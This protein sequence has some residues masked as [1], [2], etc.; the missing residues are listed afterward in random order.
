MKVQKL[1]MKLKQKLSKDFNLQRISRL[2]ITYFCS[3]HIH[4]NYA[5]FSYQELI[6]R[7]S[8]PDLKP[9]QIYPSLLVTDK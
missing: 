3:K 5:N 9:P 6:Q 7:H 1:L 8:N 4:Q 2:F